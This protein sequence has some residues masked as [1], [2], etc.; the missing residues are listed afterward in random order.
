QRH[1]DAAAFRI[2]ENPEERGED[3]RRG[4]RPD[5]HQP[6]LRSQNP[7]WPCPWW[8]S[9]GRPY[10]CTCSA[11]AKPKTRQNQIRQHYLTGAGVSAS[12]FFR[13]ASL[14]SRTAD[15]VKPAS[16]TTC[17]T[18]STLHLLSFLTL[19][20]ASLV[21]RSTLTELVSTHGRV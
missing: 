21:G 5:G 17:L 20:R 14:G 7:P 18:S 15:T 2:A 6:V 3:G 11:A 19:K 10:R 9:R 12:P 4:R 1:V 8:K 16:F 13:T